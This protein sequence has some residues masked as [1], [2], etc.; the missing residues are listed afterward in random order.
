MRTGRRA[1]RRVPA[2][3]RLSGR[4]TRALRMR[5]QRRAGSRAVRR[6]SR[7]SSCRCAPVPRAGDRPAAILPSW[8]PRR[9]SFRRRPPLPSTGTI[10][11]ARTSTTSPVLTDR[12]APRSRYRLRDGAHSRRPLEQGG[13]LASRATG[14]RSFQRVAT[15]EHQGHDGA[16]EVH[17]G[18]QRAR[19]RQQC[20]HVDAEITVRKRATEQVSGTSMMATVPA[21]TASPAPA[22]PSVCSNA[23][24]ANPAAHIAADERALVAGSPRRPL[25]QAARPCGGGEALVAGLAAAPG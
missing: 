6:H 9:Q 13:Q 4:A 7:R 3:S 14:R 15:G 2:R 20:D 5:F 16:G 22:A 19:H 17:A 10:S 11:P 1:A 18:R 12:P 23:P 21:Q 8:L 24:I 25:I